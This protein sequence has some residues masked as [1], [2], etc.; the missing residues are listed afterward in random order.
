M[1]GIVAT[2]IIVGLMGVAVVSVLLRRLSLEKAALKAT[3]DSW[4]LPQG[5]KPSELNQFLDVIASKFGAALSLQLKAT[6]MGV[7][8][9]ESRAG[10]QIDAVLQNELISSQSPLLAIA[11]KKI[12]AL[13]GLLDDNP[14]LIPVAIEKLSQFTSKNKGITS[15]NGGE[16]N[17][18]KFNQ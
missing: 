7:K 6:F 4:R 2:L 1:A 15:D 14:G 5:D 18:F 10:K 17:P 11:V 9:G 3:L 12:P 13:K 16:E 8:S